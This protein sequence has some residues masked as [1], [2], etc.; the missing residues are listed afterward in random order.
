MLM[1]T[2]K[3]PKKYTDHISIDP[4]MPD[5]SKYPFYNKILA[6]SIEFL[7]KK[8]LYRAWLKRSG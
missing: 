2:Q 6:E 1:K 7:K 5:F 3:F 8:T 4:N